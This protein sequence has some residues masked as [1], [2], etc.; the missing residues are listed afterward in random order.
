MQIQ[1]IRYYFTS[2][3]IKNQQLRTVNTN[4]EQSESFSTY[5]EMLKFVELK[6]QDSKFSITVSK[7]LWWYN[8]VGILFNE[9]GGGVILGPYVNF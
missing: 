4:A 1:D 8:G 9:G 2:M 6:F 5:D 3:L 7:L